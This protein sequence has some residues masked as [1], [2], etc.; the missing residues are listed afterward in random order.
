MSSPKSREVGPR[1]LKTVGPAC[2][3]DGVVKDLDGE[4]EVRWRDDATEMEI[5]RVAARDGL[6]EQ[7]EA[8]GNAMGEAAGK[9]TGKHGFVPLLRQRVRASVGNAIVQ[10]R[11]PDQPSRTFIHVQNPSLGNILCPSISRTKWHPPEPSPNST[12]PSPAQ[13]LILSITA[14]GMLIHPPICPPQFPLCLRQRLQ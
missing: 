5:E 9:E 10:S 8:A 11:T 7:L 13:R 2:P 6:R 1:K 3:E 4:G 14:F 12:I